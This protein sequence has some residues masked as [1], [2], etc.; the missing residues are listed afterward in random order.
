MA[1]PQSSS[2][3]AANPAS[4]PVQSSS[5]F[6]VSWDLQLRKEF[7]HLVH[8]VVMDEQ[9]QGIPKATVRLWSEYSGYTDVCETDETGWCQFDLIRHELLRVHVVVEGLS[10]S[11]EAVFNLPY[12][13][14]DVQIQFQ[15]KK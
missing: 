6:T 13:A 14:S 5:P 11:E 8:V 7:G 1:D 15:Q 10:Q 9:G 12:F 2:G 3:G 4:A